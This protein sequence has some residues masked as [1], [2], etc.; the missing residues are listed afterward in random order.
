MWN[1]FIPLG[2]LLSAY[3]PITWRNDINKSL[4][5]GWLVVQGAEFW[6]RWKKVIWVDW[7]GT[8]LGHLHSPACLP[9][10]EGLGG[11][12]SSLSALWIR[13]QMLSPRLSVW[14]G[15][16][17][18]GGPRTIACILHLPISCSGLSRSVNQIY[19]PDDQGTVCLTPKIGCR[20]CCSWSVTTKP[21]TNHTWH[22]G[23]VSNLIQLR[24][25]KAFL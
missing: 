14:H 15:W 21:H 10:V 18:T 17:L 6:E 8:S 3:L 12:V 24:I 20:C 9:G 1:S 11:S 2:L 22:W 25:L 13:T 23:I 4:P 5:G 19:H 7:S 16:G